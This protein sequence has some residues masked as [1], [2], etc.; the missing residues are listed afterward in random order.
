MADYDLGPLEHECIGRV[1]ID[2]GKLSQGTLY[3]QTCHL[4]RSSNLSERGEDR[5]T[6]TVRLRIEVPDEKKYL[7][8]G[9]K[10]PKRKWVNSQVCLH[11]PE[12]H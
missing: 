9:W 10:A 5:G 1:A 6:I 3:T 7:L 2:L 11:S 12:M 8:E 4:Y